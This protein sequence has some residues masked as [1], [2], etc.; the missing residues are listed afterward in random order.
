MTT[1]EKILNEALTLFSIKGYSDV[2]VGEIA[3]AV[4][5]KAPALYKHYKNKQEIFDSCVEKFLI[6]MNEVRNEMN[7]PDTPFS[8]KSYQTMDTEGINELATG[9]FMFYW[10]DD[11]ASKFRKMLMIG[12]YGN[13]ELNRIYEDLFINGEVEHE[14]RI[15]AELINAGV[16]RKGDP[17][18][19]ALHFYT[20]IFYLLQ[21]YDMQWDKE[22]EAKAELK[23]V[24]SEFC[25]LYSGKQG[26][27][28]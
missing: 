10:K 13:S 14:E 6:R 22:D 19:T 15:F 1:K 11:V 24:V 3:T 8:D 27:E 25:E 5:I 20:P 17:H 7:L 28:G 9:L 18:I 23:A 21:K 2:Y 4:G 12:R 26:G 16:I